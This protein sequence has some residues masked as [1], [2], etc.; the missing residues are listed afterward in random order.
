MKQ[1]GALFVRS[2]LLAVPLLFGLSILVFAYVRII[3]GDPCRAVLG[4]R[5]T[6]AEAAPSP[7]GATMS[8]PSELAA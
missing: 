3:P 5:A 8:Q 2:L 4:E 1:I 6:D 7:E